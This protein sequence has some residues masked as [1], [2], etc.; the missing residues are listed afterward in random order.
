MEL[1]GNVREQMV[2]VSDMKGRAFQGTHGAGTLDV[3]E[4]WPEAQYSAKKGDA[5]GKD[6]A[7]GSG[8]R[9]GFFGDLRAALRVSDRS[10]AIYR[11][12]SGAFA[13]AQERQAQNGF[14]CV[15]TAP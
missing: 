4:D 12:R 13:A 5:S 1:S 2:T 10:R 3:P 14:R 6:Y 8:L 7:I 11:P 15:R 9:G